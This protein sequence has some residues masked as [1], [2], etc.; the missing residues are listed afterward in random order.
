MERPVYALDMRNH[1]DSP[2]TLSHTYDEMGMDVES[3]VEEVC[4]VH[5]SVDVMGHRYLY[6]FELIP[7][8][9]AER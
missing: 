5:E 9:W 6:Y 1:G 8:A 7:A 3:F 2:W 4:G